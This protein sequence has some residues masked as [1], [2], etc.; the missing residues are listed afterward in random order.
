MER[1]RVSS[2]AGENMN[3]LI[4]EDG[5]YKFVEEKPGILVCYR[6]GV[7]WREFIGDKAVYALFEYALQ[8][9]YCSCGRK[10]S[11]P[12]CPICDNDD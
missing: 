7:R 9:E 5:K 10:L 1:V 4:L 2:Q 11:T 3:E 8:K 12:L 6:Y